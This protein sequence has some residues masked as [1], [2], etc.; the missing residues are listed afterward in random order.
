MKNISTKSIK[1]LIISSIGYIF[2][3]L[4]GR[5]LKYKFV[6]KNDVESYMNS[7]G[8]IIHCWHNQLLIGMY[9][10]RNL[11]YYVLASTS[12]D[13]DYVSSLL[14]KF[15]WKVI[16]GSSNNKAANSLVQML[17]LAK[18]GMTLAL[19]PDGPLGPLYHVESGGLYLASKTGRPIIPFS[20]TFEKK[21]IVKKSW[22]KLQIPKPFSKCVVCFGKPYFITEKLTE[23]NLENKKQSLKQAIKDINRD[24]KRILQLWK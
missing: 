17:R 4:L 10:L 5:S 8:A 19:T 11:N 7:N 12:K 16:R 22:D 15:G 13:G 23:E 24:G 6:G 2:L 3:K 18:K 9:C 1:F 20:L 14:K 21:W